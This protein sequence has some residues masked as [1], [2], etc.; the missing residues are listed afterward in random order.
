MSS[1]RVRER[2]GGGEAKPNVFVRSSFLTRVDWDEDEEY[3]AHAS[4]QRRQSNK[5]R[6]E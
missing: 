4:N 1:F 5:E 6:L 2:V 3:T